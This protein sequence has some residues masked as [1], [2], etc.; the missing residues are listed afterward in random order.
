MAEQ[1]NET[2]VVSSR[3]FLRLISASDSHTNL[4]F[5]IFRIEPVNALADRSLLLSLADST[6][7]GQSLPARLRIEGSENGGFAVVLMNRVRDKFH[8]HSPEGK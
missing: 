3:Y 1:S 7:S 6:R 5:S 4:R 2:E 8:P